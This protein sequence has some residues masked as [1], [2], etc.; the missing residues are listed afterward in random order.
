MNYEHDSVLQRI[1]KAL[2]LAHE[3]VLKEPLPQRWVDLILYL[4]EKEQERSKAREPGDKS[5]GGGCLPPQNDESD[6]GTS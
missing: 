4:D 5:P 6:R 1:G 2:H 3:D